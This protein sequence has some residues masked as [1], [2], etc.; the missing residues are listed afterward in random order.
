MCNA[1]SQQSVTAHSIVRCL[2][3]FV[4]R[5]TVAVHTGTNV[6]GGCGVPCFSFALLSSDENEKDKK[7]GDFVIH[8]GTTYRIMNP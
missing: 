7:N 3:S 2:Y 8:V 1:Y 4:G 5:S 6:K